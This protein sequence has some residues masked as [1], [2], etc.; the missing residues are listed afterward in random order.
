MSSSRQSS[1][2]GAA[3][4]SNPFEIG[5]GSL[6]PRHVPLKAA[7]RASPSERALMAGT[8]LKMGTGAGAGM[9][10]SNRHT[11]AYMAQMYAALEDMGVDTSDD[12][13]RE[14][15]DPGLT[16]LGARPGQ[17]AVQ[18]GP[19]DR[20]GR[21]ADCSD[22]P[23]LCMSVHGDLAVVGSA[24]H[25][26]VE[27]SL[28]PS[29][30]GTTLTKKRTLYTKQYGHHE[31]VTDVSHCPDGRVLSAGMDSKLCLWNAA[32]QPRCND[33][34]GHTGSIAKVL[35][36]AD[37]AL[38]LS[39]GYDKSLRFWSLSSCKE[40]ICLRAHRAP[41]MHLAWA[42]GVLASADRDGAVVSW[43]VTT[44]DATHLGA[45]GGHATALAAA[46]YA[47]AGGG[48]AGVDGESGG[49]LPRGLVSGGQDGVVRLW[50][51]RMTGSGKAAM[52]TRVHTGAVNDL[53]AH[54]M[55]NGQPLVI[56]SG[57][58]KRLLTLDPRMSLQAVHLFE[59]HRDFIYSLHAIGHIAISGAGDGSVLLHDL[60]QGKCMYG[61]GANR[62]AVRALHADTNRLVC[63]GD[64][65]SI[66]SAAEQ[67]AE[68]KRVAMEKAE[69]LKAE[70]RAKEAAM[71]GAGASRASRPML[72]N[73]EWDDAVPPPATIP[74]NEFGTPLYPPGHP[75]GPPLRTAPAQNAAQ[76]ELD[77]LHALGDK[78]FGKR[79][80]PNS[81]GQ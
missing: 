16:T 79:R 54:K 6:V 34:L 15:F 39:A 72:P 29:T 18:R 61:L 37:N 70:R 7:P 69:R 30:D 23:L 21:T 27:L 41:V 14:S 32:G 44:G 76:N 35:A 26:L 67:F 68:K 12:K 80:T 31:W 62:A 64:D 63:A 53:I 58:D 78:K 65:G 17:A 10:A 45:H 55:P 59:D 52:E 11:D 43:D 81:D 49:L 42:G 4:P 36:S 22:R 25:G 66:L 50:D 46:S 24:D 1:S 71:G 75:M 2:R 60:Q 57:A 56:S 8:P 74:R 48:A 3:V 47:E 73:A 38:G 33:L 40:V 51:L 20:Q 9:H 5:G 13:Y 77:A 19:L 28:A